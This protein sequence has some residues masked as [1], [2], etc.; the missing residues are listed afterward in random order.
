MLFE[1]QYFRKEI[2]ILFNADCL[3]LIKEKIIRKY[4]YSV[5]ARLDSLEYGRECLSV[6]TSRFYLQRTTIVQINRSY[7]PDT[8]VLVYMDAI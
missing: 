3:Q 1:Y 6:L 8:Y 7:I 5:D 2:S 4:R